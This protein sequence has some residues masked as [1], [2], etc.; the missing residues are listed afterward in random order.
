MLASATNRFQGHFDYGGEYDEEEDNNEREFNEDKEK[1]YYCLLMVNFIL[2]MVFSV[3]KLN[4]VN[5]IYVGPILKTI[6]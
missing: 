3:L 5:N 1:Y 4:F 6:S 2:K